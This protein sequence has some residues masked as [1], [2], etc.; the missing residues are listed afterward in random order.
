MGE[1]SKRTDLLSWPTKKARFAHSS[2]NSSR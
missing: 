2:I 1:C